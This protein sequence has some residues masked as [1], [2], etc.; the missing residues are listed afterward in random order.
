MRRTLAAAMARS[1][2]EIPHYYLSSEI[3][4]GPAMGW[5]K[6]ENERRRPAERLLPGVLFVKAVALALRRAPELNARW[7]GDRAEPAEHI[8]PGVAIALRGGGLV[9][10]ALHDADRMEIT[11]LMAAF[12]DLVERT[13]AG[14][15]RSSELSDGTMTVTSLG[16]LGADSVLP[17]IYPPQVAIVGF[18]RIV[19]RVRAVAGAP[20]VRPVV[21]CTLAADHRVSDGIRGS[22]FLT[23]VESLLAE[24]EKL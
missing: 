6:I 19:D 9:A 4:L 1:K 3:D 17:V 7:S 20:V 21:T 18:G 5:L 8:H 2:R 16:E 15:L 13:R 24:P 14:L 10:P 12:R 23:T 11:A 22:V